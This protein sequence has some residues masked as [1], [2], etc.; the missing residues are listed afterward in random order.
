V[1]TIMEVDELWV[2]WQERSASYQETWQL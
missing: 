2:C 1:V